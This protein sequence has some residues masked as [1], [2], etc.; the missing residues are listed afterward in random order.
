VVCYDWTWVRWIDDVRYDRMEHEFRVMPNRLSE[1]APSTLRIGDGRL[2][3]RF[4]G[5]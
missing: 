2:V 5:W 4:V 3:F 1:L